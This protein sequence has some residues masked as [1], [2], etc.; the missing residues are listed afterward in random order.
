MKGKTPSPILVLGALITVQFLFGVNYVFAKIIV[1]A[2]PPLVWAS[3]RIVI[4][5]LM[6]ISIAVL[7]G[8]KHPKPDRHFFVPLILFAALGMIIN[9]STFLLGLRYTSATNSAILC[10]LIPVFTLVL[11]T[12]RRQEPMTWMRLAGF[13]SA[14]SGVLVIRRIE[15]FRLSDQTVVGDLLTIVN[16]LS[17]ALFLS[18]GKKFLEK[19]DRPWTTAWLF[20]YGSFGIGLVSVPSWQGFVW[21]ALTPVL[22]GSM[23]FNIVGGTLL[24]YFLNFWAL[25]HAKSSSVALFIYTQPIFAALLAWGWLGEAPT[26][27]STLATLLIFLGMFLAFSREP[28]GKPAPSR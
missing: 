17:Y 18:Y 6:M 14:F 27:R 4:A 16:A 21:P 25:A 7:S 9:Q 23:I 11:V 5:T 26:L 1:E 2:F 15:D 3:I 28:V 22:V 20:I 13:I 19:Y 8:H 10:T 12:L 24:T